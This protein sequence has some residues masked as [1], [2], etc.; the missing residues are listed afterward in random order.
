MT[1]TLNGGAATAIIIF[2]VL[3]S[4]CIVAILEHRETMKRLEIEAHKEKNK[5]EI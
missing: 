3:V 2:L 5:E 1:I 4:A